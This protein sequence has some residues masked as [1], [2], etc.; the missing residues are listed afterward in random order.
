MAGS[1]VSFGIASIFAGGF[2]HNDT[3]YHTPANDVHIDKMTPYSEEDCPTWTPAM[4][5][6]VDCDGHVFMSRH[7][8]ARSNSALYESLQRA[9]RCAA[10]TGD[11]CL[12]SHEVG[13]DIP[14]AFLWHEDSIRMVSFPSIVDGQD[15]KRVYIRPRYSQNIQ[16][17]PQPAEPPSEMDAGEPEPEGSIQGDENIMQ[18]LQPLVTPLMTYGSL[19][20]L[21]PLFDSTHVHDL[22]A[23][24]FNR[25]IR[26][27]HNDLFR[28]DVQ[29]ETFHDDDAYCIQ[30]LIQSLPPDCIIAEPE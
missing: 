12:L 11:S 8:A 15:A 28:G 4:S 27:A 20:A 7:N 2:L 21:A 16:N 9:K 22:V 18:R 10:A 17:S 24:E 30:H 23:F 19:S 3:D 25:T 29:Y 1:A 13:L 5:V 14:A 6:D 26:V